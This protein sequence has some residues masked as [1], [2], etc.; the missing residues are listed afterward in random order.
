MPM[1]RWFLRGL[2]SF[3]GATSHNCISCSSLSLHSYH[4]PPPIFSL[5]EKTEEKARKLKFTYFFYSTTEHFFF[6]SNIGMKEVKHKIHLSPS[7]YPTDNRYYQ[8]CWI[9]DFSRFLHNAG[10]R[11]RRKK[12]KHCSRRRSSFRQVFSQRCSRS[13]STLSS[14]HQLLGEIYDERARKILLH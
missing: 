10:G 3:C 8:F 5:R 2:G 7:L 11:K 6:K 9:N 13:E 12:S 1:V 4:H 14:W